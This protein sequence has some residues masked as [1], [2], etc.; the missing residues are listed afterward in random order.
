MG[1]RWML[2][3]VALV[4]FMAGSLMAQ[5]TPPK[6][7][8]LTGAELQTY[9]AT[10]KDWQ[11]ENAAFMKGATTR[12]GQGSMVL[13]A[14]Q[15]YQVCLDRHHI[16]REEFNWAGQ[17]AAE[18]WS[19]MTY[20]DG[21]YKNQKAALDTEDALQD[22]AIAGAKRDLAKFME[23]QQNGARILSDADRDAITKQ[24]QE[25][26]KAALDEVKRRADDAAAAE[27]DAQQHDADAKSAEQEAQNPPADV[28]ADD[29]PIYVEN[30]KN[31]A[32]AAQASA[33]EAR[34]EEADAK[35]SEAEAQSRADA[36]KA[37]AEHPEI[38][39]SDEEKN[40]AKAEND[41]GIK[42]AEAQIETIT[43]QKQDIA[44]HRAKLEKTR[45]EMIKGIPDENISLMRLY[46]D[47][48]REVMAAGA[49]TTRGSL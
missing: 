44:A 40:V 18:A 36:A 49:G 7:N 20:L 9:L 37:R 16:T 23:A 46:G 3:L 22:D 34:V 13:D 39:V 10:Q 28:A 26:Q 4:L 14:G 45:T 17:R 15:R 19:A 32:S 35:T 41:E 2:G 1:Q 42:R 48:Y 38:A 31:E 25:D 6:D 5:W 12:S 30:K 33:K 8:K 43:Q 21:A 11:E 24:A 47:Q 29:R 27:S